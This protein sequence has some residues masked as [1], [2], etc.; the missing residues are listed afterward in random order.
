MK[1]FSGNPC[2]PLAIVLLVIVSVLFAGCT[3]E[4]A[5]PPATPAVAAGGNPLATL[6]Y[7]I[8][9]AVPADWTREDPGTSSEKDYGTTTLSIARFTSPATIPGEAA[10]KNTLAIDLDQNPGGDFE[11]YFNQATLA[12]GKTYDTAGDPHSTVKSS[13]LEI[14]GHKSCMLDFQTNEVRGSY[15]FTSTDQGMYIFAFKGEN[16]PVPVGALQK[17]IAGM[18]KSIR[19]APSDK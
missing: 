15:I 16:K 9:I 8:S 6:P 18:Y 10:S 14:A 12:L 13:T 19:I 7:G 4:P 11:I 17:E 2:I 5:S 1:P 3:S